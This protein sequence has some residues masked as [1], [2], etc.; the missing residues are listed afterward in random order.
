[1]VILVPLV[2]PATH[3]ASRAGVAQCHVQPAAEA[4]AI[5]A[6]GYL[7]QRFTQ[8]IRFDEPALPA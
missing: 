5:Y 3:A 2:L 7:P 6:R 1:V 8:H 4:L